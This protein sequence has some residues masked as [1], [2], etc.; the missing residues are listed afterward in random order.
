[1]RIVTLLARHG[2]DKYGDA[3]AAM[4]AL[5]ARQMPDADRELLIVD[6]ALPESHVEALGPGR[7]LIGASNSHWEFSAWDRGL[8]HLGKRL[9]GFDFVH[10][11]TSAFGALYTRYLDRF[12]TGMLALL[13]GR[14]A[15]VGHLDYYNETVTICG[16]S[17]RSW[18]RCSFVFLPPVELKLLGSLVGVA[19]PSAFFSGNPQQPFRADAPLS[20]T[21]RDNIIGWLT[22]SGTGQSVQW[23]SRFELT[24]ETLA[25]FE[26]KT[27]AILNEQ[28]LSSRLRAQGCALVDAIWLATRPGQLRAGRLLGEIPS[29]RVQ[30]TQRDVDPAPKTLLGAD[31][32][33]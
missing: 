22:G 21:Y 7:A 23:H 18:L 12:D 33:N 19:D 17:L 5:F 30:L 20:K 26:A 9:D 2:T 28:M 6:T 25:L 27:L 1:V 15:A 31:D 32:A 8:R 3:V 10:L 24:A 4:D 29:W 14:A 11:A 16:R 13:Q